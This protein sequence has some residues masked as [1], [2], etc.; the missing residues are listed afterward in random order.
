MKFSDKNS[1][2]FHIKYQDLLSEYFHFFGGKSFSII[3]RVCF[4]NVMT[5]KTRAYQTIGVIGK[6]NCDIF[7]LSCVPISSIY[8]PANLPARQLL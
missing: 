6:L 7:L 4:R 1:D 2:I 5:S 8:R 3:E